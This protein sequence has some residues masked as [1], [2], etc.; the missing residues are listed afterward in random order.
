MLSKNYFKFLAFF[1]IS[2]LI[3]FQYRDKVIAA[4][5]GH[6]VISEMGDSCDFVEIYNPTTSA[7]DLSTWSVQRATSAGTAWT[8]IPLSGSVAAGAYFLVAATNPCNGVTPNVT[9]A[10]LSVTTN[11]HF[12]LVSNTTSLGSC[13]SACA[14]ASGVVDFVGTGTAASFEGTATANP[15]A[16][17]SRHRLGNMY[18]A[19]YRDG[20]VDTNQNAND[21]YGE[22]PSP[23]SG[24]PP[25]YEPTTLGDDTLSPCTA[26]SGILI[27]HEI[28]GN[29]Y[30]SST[31]DEAQVDRTDDCWRIQAQTI[32]GRTNDNSS[33]AI[34]EDDVAN[35]NGNI[36]TTR[37]TTVING[38]TIP[39]WSYTGIA[40][41]GTFV[42][43]ATQ[44]DYTPTAGTGTTY[45]ASGCAGSIFPISAVGVMA[46]SSPGITGI[47]QDGSS[48]NNLDKPGL[49][50]N[51]VDDAYNDA[52]T[53]LASSPNAVLFDFSLNPTRSFGAY[54]ADLETRDPQTLT[55][56]LCEAHAD[57]TAADC[58]ASPITGVAG[59]TFTG[60]NI[61]DPIG[62]KL[63][64]VILF[65]TACNLISTS[66]VPAFLD[67]N[68]DGVNET[69]LSATDPDNYRNDSCGGESGASNVGC[70]NRTT[71]FIGFANS[72]PV[73]YMLVVIG[74]DDIQGADGDGVYATEGSGQITNCNGA[75]S[76]GLF[77]E[78][79]QAGNESMSFFSPTILTDNTAATAVALSNSASQLESGD[80]QQFVILTIF[81]LLLST[82]YFT[83][84]RRKIQ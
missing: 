19:I 84:S 13:T 31:L 63:A 74:D 61:G 16:A 4:G 80:G 53:G 34:L 1:A 67:D 25:I 10:S 65:D 40:G 32:L 83:L 72:N 20:M 82:V 36:S 81:S 71:R 55:Y 42:F 18:F 49:N 59:G 8:V 33:F 27:S 43:T 11:N 2:C 3:F 24:I 46:I 22:S 76:P 23:F 14:S 17:N 62:G 73:A 51:E 56:E 45:P 57:H 66:S 30:G 7:Q 48:D 60:M 37:N 64:Q 54:F 58:S 26:T 79:C 68:E 9:N 21:F 6:L 69:P 5:P 35:V 77:G 52:G 12:A 28:S 38:I 75:T 29:Q 78:A 15:T 39:Q 47:P 41:G 50:T 70:G 44:M